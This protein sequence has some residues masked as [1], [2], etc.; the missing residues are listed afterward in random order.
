MC[1]CA[2]CVVVGTALNIVLS[3]SM[4]PGLGK[5][6]Q[7]AALLSAL[8]TS[9]KLRP[10]IIVCPATVIN[11]WMREL[12]KWCVWVPG[13]PLRATA[14]CDHAW[15]LMFCVHDKMPGHPHF[16]CLWFTALG[17]LWPAAFRGVAL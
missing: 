1:A 4:I 13:W 8:K 16:V 11:H 7:V 9:G 15:L 6:I 3:N 10:S 12:H 17:V 14:V 2:W 5:T